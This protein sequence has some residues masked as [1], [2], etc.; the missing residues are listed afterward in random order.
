M[1]TR[2]PKPKL[3]RQILVA[4]SNWFIDFRVGDVD[5]T[6]RER[7]DQWLRQSPEHI[8]AYIEIAKTYVELPAPNPERP[9]DDQKLIAYAHS[10]GNVV[11]FDSSTRA[12]QPLSPAPKP[13]WPIHAASKGA[14]EPDASCAGPRPRGGWIGRKLLAASVATICVAATFLIWVAVYRYPTYTTQIGERL[15]ITLGDGSTVELNARSKVRIRF[16]EVERSVELINGQALFEVAK[17]K[18]RP[19][20]VRSGEAVV[21]AVGTEFDVY[22]KRDA[23]TVTVIEGRVAVLMPGAPNSSALDTDRANVDTSASRQMRRPAVF[24]AAGEQVVVTNRVVRAPQRADVAVA[25]AWTQRRL[26]F[27]GSALSDVIE[28]FNRYNTRQLVIEDPQLNDFHVSGVYSS[29]D[30]ASLIRFL[31]AQPGVEVIEMDE[32]VRITKK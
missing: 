13:N 9:I 28:D 20:M 23:T 7:F 19:F 5:S 25:T 10:E 6:A 14:P 3:N 32:E 16:S 1:K 4:A 21:R 29:T 26:V 30:P 24:V 12:D 31:R 11:P 22:R 15:S 18:A 8:R 2:Q 17:D 27:E